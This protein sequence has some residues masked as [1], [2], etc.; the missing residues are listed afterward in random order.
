MTYTGF[1]RITYA[2]IQKRKVYVLILALSGLISN[3][4][5]FVLDT[6]QILLTTTQC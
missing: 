5:L 6:Q 1:Q 4:F 2:E 3:L